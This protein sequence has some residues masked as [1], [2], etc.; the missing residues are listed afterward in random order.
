MTLDEANRARVAIDRAGIFA[1]VH[2]AMD[3][4][5]E[6]PPQQVESAWLPSTVAFVIRMPSSTQ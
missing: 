2:V 4:E 5:E 3:P 1:S 6:A